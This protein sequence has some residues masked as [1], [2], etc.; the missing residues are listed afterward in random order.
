MSS[1]V[2][3]FLNLH[4]SDMSGVS[5]SGSSAFTT[6]GPS[7]RLMY[8][9]TAME[10]QLDR[11]Y[12]AKVY[13]SGDAITGSVVIAPLR[14][15]PFDLFEIVLLGVA[16]TRVDHIS[17]PIHANHT[18][19]KLIMPI[20]ESA[21]PT[22][23]ML[24][25]GKVYTL[26]LH[27]V[28]P[29]HLTLGACNHKVASPHV[30]SHHT[31]LPPTMG[32]YGNRTSSHSSSG[33]T[34]DWE[35]DDMAPE[36]ASIEYTIKARIYR[37]APK[38][39]GCGKNV[40]SKI[41]EALHPVRILPASLV[42]PPLPISKSDVIYKLQSNK[43]VRKGLFA[44]SKIGTV[45]AT[46]GDE[47]NGTPQPAPIVLRPDAVSAESTTARVKLL[48]E[49]AR[50]D[51]QPPHIT[52]WSAKL[53]SYTHF[54]ATAIS[55]FPNLGGWSQAESHNLQRQGT[56]ST[57]VVVNNKPLKDQK[58]E[59][60]VDTGRRD[61]GYCSTDSADSAAGSAR[62]VTPPGSPS[63]KDVGI[64][65]SST[66][67]LEVALPMHKRTFL[68]TFHSCI[69][70]RTYS[71]QLSVTMVPAS[72][73]SSSSSSSSASATTVNVTVPLQIVVGETAIKEDTEGLPTFEAA[74]EEA[75]ADAHLQPR[76]LVVPDAQYQETSLL[77]SYSG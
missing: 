74:L 64:I 68:P 34:A 47:R 48:F 10:I 32:A 13:N 49:P 40:Y 56:Y 73:T 65:Y 30:H 60:M 62:Q 19:L 26:P 71:L 3:L 43:T 24:E 51:S 39:D 7:S 23:R 2:K 25:A 45:T 53:T 54:S 61:S 69:L 55:S 70:S 20:E 76:V 46:T 35:R 16:H 50:P 4:G 33:N 77:P 36:M 63:S 22:P 28:V 44:R 11:H 52:G 67:D 57:S 5:D 6:S 59:A 58:W 12:Q 1:R 66:L 41:V 27:F 17:T 42:D 8:P 21:Y 14:D 38:E 29:H 9:K 72:S 31:M 15:I 37:E 75:E 18:F